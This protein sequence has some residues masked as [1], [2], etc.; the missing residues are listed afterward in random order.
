MVSDGNGRRVET[1]FSLDKNAKVVMV[2]LRDLP[3]VLSVSTGQGC[4]EK[5]MG[6]GGYDS[7]SIRTRS[8][9]PLR[10]DKVSCTE[11]LFLYVKGLRRRVVTCPRGSTSDKSRP[12]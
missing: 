10:H 5:K 2:G 7:D 1:H 9:R 4:V 3:E 6:R 8:T 12:G 11:P